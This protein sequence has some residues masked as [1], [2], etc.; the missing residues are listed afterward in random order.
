VGLPAGA[1]EFAAD[2]DFQARTRVVDVALNDPAE[3]RFVR[4]MK[5]DPNASSDSTLVIMAPPAALVGK[6]AATT[7]KQQIIANLHAAGKCC[8]DPHCKH[9]Q[10]AK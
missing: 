2:P 4:D 8:N 10:K 3:S 5:I 6:F 7:T 1:A 9:N